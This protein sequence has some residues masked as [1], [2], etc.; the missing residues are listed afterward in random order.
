MIPRLLITGAFLAEVDLIAEKIDGKR[1]YCPRSNG[2]SGNLFPLEIDVEVFQV[3]VGNLEAALNLQGRMMNPD[4]PPVKEVLFLGSAGIYPFSALEREWV[5]PMERSGNNIEHTG[6]I[7]MAR[8]Y[9]NLEWAV[10]MG[11]AAIPELMQKYVEGMAGPWGGYI[12]SGLNPLYGDVNSPDS[13]TLSAETPEV[14]PKFGKRISFENMEAFGLAYLSH[15]KGVP[16]SSFFSLTNLVG[17][18]GSDSWKKNYRSG[19][20]QLQRMIL[21]MMEKQKT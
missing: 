8:N 14:G 17:P 5:E 13:I 3:G 1:L 16:F 15:L 11:E 6:S 19:S 2:A 4:L 20:L 9:H 18:G 21:S 12:A 10:L 7:G